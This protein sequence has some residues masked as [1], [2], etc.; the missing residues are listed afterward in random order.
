MPG[1]VRHHRY[2]ELF[3]YPASSVWWMFIPNPNGGKALRESTGQR[4]DVAAH[5]VFLQRVRAPVDTGPKAKQRGL[6]DALVARL[7]WLETNRKAN[8]PTRKKLAE[9]TVD[10]YRKKSG[11]L[12]RL[13]GPDTLLSE[14]G[15]EQ[16]RDYIT[17]RTEEGAKGTSIDKELTTLSM[18]MELARKDGVECGRMRDLKPADFKTTYVPKE[19]WLTHDEYDL[20]TAWW[21]ANREASRGGILDF[22]V[23][24]GATY[25]SEVR[26]TGRSDIKEKI[27]TREVRGRTVKVKVFEVR[28]RGTKRET[29]DRTFD[30]PSD[31]QHL[32]ER[33]LKHLDGERGA[34]F[35][36][37]GNIRRDILIAC[38]YLSM[39][40][41]CQSSK[42]LW[43]RNGDAWAK[44]TSQQAGTPAR[45]PECKHCKAVKVFEPFSPTDLRRTF[46]QWLMQA[47]VPYEFAYPIMGH[48]DDR[49][50]KKI[51]GRRSAT[52]VG[53]HIEAVLARAPKRKVSGVSRV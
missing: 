38:A 52:D 41:T 2:P 13:L 16:I 20:F 44:G 30:I 32:F 14:I 53:P 39:C 3:K 12:V 5:R 23:S 47:G 4:D 15:N 22:I 46:A 6:N 19:R 42:N 43:W 11:T 48:S 36:S 51:Y 34:L 17:A 8:D 27:V 24:T 26:N 9:D 25:P 49:M 45:D 31:R 33:A 21:Y 50:L 10:F 40:Q 7:T 28:I 37:W 29:R 35:R 18:A 1:Y